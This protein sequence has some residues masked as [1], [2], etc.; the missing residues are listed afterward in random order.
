VIGEL[1]QVRHLVF[2]M[3]SREL[4]RELYRNPV[5]QIDKVHDKARA[6]ESALVSGIRYPFQ[7]FDRSSVEAKCP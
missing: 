6:E 1:G 4:N 2:V 7:P 3:L 5:G